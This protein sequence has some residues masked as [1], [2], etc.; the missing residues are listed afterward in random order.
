MSLLQNGGQLL[1]Q[2]TPPVSM[3]NDSPPFG[4]P[5]M[6]VLLNQTPFAPAPLPPPAKE[7]Q[8]T[9]KES[10]G[11]TVGEPQPLSFYSRVPLPTHLQG[12]VR[13][14]VVLDP[15]VEPTSYYP[16]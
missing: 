2:A 9:D 7:T 8:L 11:A 15:Q 14:L 13:Y 3:I 5:G 10:R 1:P 4:V 6:P 16:T 12:Y